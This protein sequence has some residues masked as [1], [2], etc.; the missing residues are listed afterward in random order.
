MPVID[1]DL[2]AAGSFQLGS[3]RVNR[4]GYG[5]LQLAGDNAFGPPRDRRRG[6]SG[7]VRGRQQRDQSHRYEPRY[8]GAGVV[9]ELIYD[10]RS[11]RTP[12]TWRL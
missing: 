12:A 1:S 6:R 8:Y 11:I 2:E 3:W 7:F 4:V 5:A 10:R 9:N